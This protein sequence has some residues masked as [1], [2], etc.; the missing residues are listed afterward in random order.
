M[1]EQGQCIHLEKVG[2]EVAGEEQVQPYTRGIC[3]A[4]GT[5]LNYTRRQIYSE[6]K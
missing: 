3:S 5:D 6:R 4:A 2:T 1:T